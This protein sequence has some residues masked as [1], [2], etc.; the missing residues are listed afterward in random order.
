MALRRIY[1]QILSSTSGFDLDPEQIFSKHMG[2]I[3]GETSLSA[4]ELLQEAADLMP[5]FSIASAVA[6]YSEF[7]PV[8]EQA[9]LLGQTELKELT[10]DLRE[11]K[12]Q[13]EKTFSPDEEKQ[14]ELDGAYLE[15]R[16]HLA[17]LESCLCV[18]Q[19]AGIRLL[20]GDKLPS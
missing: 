15:A 12:I 10:K 8:Q 6:M 4:E 16:Y 17:L 14:A 1:T 7:L 18:S 9:A 2:E 11:L 20:P 19:S 3:R 13:L 5:S